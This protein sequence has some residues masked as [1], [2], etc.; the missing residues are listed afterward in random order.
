MFASKTK[1]LSRNGEQRYGVCLLVTGGIIAAFG[2]VAS[3]VLPLAFTL[4]GISDVWL[5]NL[6]DV[7]LYQPYLIGFA[8]LAIGYGFYQ[9]YWHRLACTDGDLCA[10]P[11]PSLVVRSGLWVGTIIVVL[12]ASF[13]IWFPAL[14]PNPS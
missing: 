12:A 13:P 3:C 4:L 6:H 11:L 9:V 5:A 14:V 10:L 2:A 7:G 1:G 8:I